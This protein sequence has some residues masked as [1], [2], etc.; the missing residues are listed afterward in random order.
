MT[1]V[2]ISELKTHPSKIILKSD[3]YPI[4]VENRNK[5]KA[6]LIGKDLFEKIIAYLEDYADVKTV[7]ET[8]FSQGRDFEKVARELGI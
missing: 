7:R 2:S 6:Y 3:D 4:A 8:N 5:I 1:T